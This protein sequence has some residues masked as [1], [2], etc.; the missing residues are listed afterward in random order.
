[1]EVKLHVRQDVG[2]GKP[3]VLLHGMFADGSQWEKIT[4]LLKDNYRV[5]VIDLLGH[6]KSPRPKNCKY[7]VKDHVTSL[8]KTLVDLKAT[9]DLIVVG[10]SMGGSVALAYC[11]SFNI[12]QL[13]LISSPFYLT[14]DQ[15]ILSNFSLTVTL[16]KLSTYFFSRLEGSLNNDGLLNKAVRYGDNSK[17][18]HELIGANDNKLDATIIQ[19]NLKNLIRSFNFAKYLAKTNTPTTFYAGKKDVF[20]IQ[21]Q[22]YALK[23]F[24]PNIDIQRLD[25][26]KID[27]MLVQNLPKEI[28]SLLLKNQKNI[29]N[30]GIDTGK[31]NDIVF[32]HGIESS[33]YYWQHLMPTFSKKHRV[34]AI[35][36]LGFGKSPKPKNIAYNLEDHVEWLSRTIKEL[37][38]K[39]FT[40]VGHSL[41]SLIAHAYATKHTPQI[42][43]IIL[44]SPVTMDFKI[45]SKNVSSKALAWI[46]KLDDVSYIYTKLVENFGEKNINKFLPTLRT[47]K[48]TLSRSY[49]S[50]LG[51]NKLNVPTKIYYGNLDPLIDAAQISSLADNYKNIEVHELKNKTHNFVLTHPKI[52]IEAIDNS[53]KPKESL[54]KA[55]IIP[56]NMIKQF[57]NLAVPRIL[58]KAITYLAV[59]ILLFSKFAP[60]VFVLYLA[61][62]V[63]FQGV[64]I[65]QGAFSLRNE[66][67][68][69]FSYIILG[70]FAYLLGY[71][72]IKHPTF[73]L[74]VAVIIMC[75]GVLMYGLNNLVVATFWLKKSKNK[76][77]LYLTGVPMV[78]LGA[79]AL[80][81]AV[82]SAYLIVY[83][84]AG[85]LLL[86]SLKMFWISFIGLIAAYIRGFNQI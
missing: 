1:M 23:K 75:S 14:A 44:F 10:Y 62:F 66:G 69:Y 7:T 80:F 53:L 68:A 25:I 37:G 51:N 71:S 33:S 79:L 58:L 8:R 56:N 27:H 19:L 30:I 48:N 61:I 17:K 39:K 15:M 52:A 38:L 32:L 42:K 45:K 31:G 26:I 82:S 83:I 34:I 22:L 29:L 3:I 2:V 28:A 24:N 46:S 57:V 78:V 20:I 54:P 5:I 18:F 86:L 43:N 47:L 21:G 74:K 81:G 76:N 85:Y 36:L 12:K 73:S 16:T 63:C 6:G 60:I 40:L 13:V 59:A 41:G 65:I 9:K 4:K 64:K 35:D 55:K 11:A 72:L 67:L 77:M 84:F 50:P 70:L 49:H